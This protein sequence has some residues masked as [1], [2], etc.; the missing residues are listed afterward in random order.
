MTNISDVARVAGVSVATVSRALRGI[1]TVQESTRQ[2]VLE[3]A[4]ELDYVVSPTAA[5]LASGRTRVIGI[6]TP[7]LA[8]WFFANA[9]SAIERRCAS[10]DS[11][12]S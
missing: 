1:N 5:S 6:I 3:A 8:R 2:R 10:M 4:A 12:R 9:I 7:F 11:T